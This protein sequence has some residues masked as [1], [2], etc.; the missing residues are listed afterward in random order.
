[1]FFD[2]ISFTTF[3]I[4]LALGLFIVYVYGTDMKII[5]V[6]P[7]PENISQV[8]YKD[9][10]DNCFTFEANEVKCPTDPAKIKVVPIQS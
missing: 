3:L 7:T 8:L 5:Y 2:K 9:Q 4:S 10:A 1:M 6:Y